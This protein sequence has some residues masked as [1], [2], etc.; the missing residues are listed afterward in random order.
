MPSLHKSVT[1][2]GN[3]N[4]FFLE[5]ILQKDCPKL[6]LRFIAL[7]ALI[8]TSPPTLP[9]PKLTLAPWQEKRAK[10]IMI[11]K[12]AQGVSIAQVARECALSR[13][14]FSRAFKSATGYAPRDW[15]RQEKITRAK[16][17]LSHRSMS[18]SE[19]C[20]ECGFSDQSHLTRTFTKVVGVSPRR[21]RTQQFAT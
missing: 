12:M 4:R 16:E 18:I 7:P 13:S 3:Q 15:L 21:W 11:N 17:L 10:N 5:S 20:L 2:P 14:H 19:I 9:M 6:E 1:L 8:F